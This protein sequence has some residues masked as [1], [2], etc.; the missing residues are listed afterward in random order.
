[1]NNYFIYETC[2]TTAV[3]MYHYFHYDHPENVYFPYT[4]SNLNPSDSTRIKGITS[5]RP[6]WTNVACCMSCTLCLHRARVVTCSVL[7]L[8]RQFVGNPVTGITP[9]SCTTRSRHTSFCTGIS[10]ELL[11]PESCHGIIF[12]FVVVAPLS[13]PPR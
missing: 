8:C 3:D 7:L 9:P 13:F 4:A 11:E 1:M 5:R 2:T 12:G 6:S 10:I